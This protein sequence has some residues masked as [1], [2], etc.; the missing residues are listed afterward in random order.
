MNKTIQPNHKK[1]E[2]FCIEQHRQEFPE[3]TTEIWNN[4]AENDLIDSGWVDYLLNKNLSLSILRK[5]RKPT[6]NPYT[7]YGLDGLSRK[8]DQINLIQVKYYDP[9]HTISKNS[10]KTF[11]EIHKNLKTKSYLYHIGKVYKEFKLIS[12]MNFRSPEM[13]SEYSIKNLED[14]QY[15]DIIDESKLWEHQRD[16]LKIMKDIMEDTGFK[17]MRSLELCPGGGKTD[18]TGV[19]I[20]SIKKIKYVIVLNYRIPFVQQ[21][22]NR[23]S[24]YIEK[25]RKPYIINSE[26]SCTV[27]HILNTIGKRKALINITYDSLHLIKDVKDFNDAFFIVDESHCMTPSIID[28]LK[29]KRGYCMTGTCVDKIST[30]F[31]KFYSLPLSEAIEKKIVTDYK[32][33]LPIFDEVDEEDE[34]EEERLD[35]FI[36]EKSDFENSD[37]LTEFE[38][39]NNDSQY[40]VENTKLL[41]DKVD[42]LLTG[43]LKTGA[44]YNITYLYGKQECRNFRK[45]LEKRASSDIYNVNIDVKIVIHGV[46][47]RDR[48]DIFNSFR[49]NKNDGIVLNIIL[50]C[51]VLDMAIDLKLCDSVYFTQKSK[52]KNISLFVQRICRGNRIDKGNK[53]KFTRVFI[54]G[55]DEC[56]DHL[57]NLKD[58]DG[59]FIDKVEKL[60]GDYTKSGSDDR[61]IEIDETFNV[62]RTI[63]DV[64]EQEKWSVE[65]KFTTWLDHCSKKGLVL[66]KYK[67]EKFNMGSFQD[68]MFYAISGRSNDYKKELPG[69]LEKIEQHEELCKN[70]QV[71]IDKLK[72]SGEKRIFSNEEKFKIWFDYCSKKGIAPTKYIIDDFCLGGFQNNLIHAIGGMKNLYAK[73]V[74]NW[75]EKIKEN[76]K[77]YVSILE[78][79]DNIKE[80]KE[81]EK[82]TRDEKFTKW[83]EY[84][85]K[86]VMPDQDFMLGN[87]NLGRFQSS[88]L[89]S[90]SDHKRKLFKNKKIEWMEKIKQNDKLYATIVKRIGKTK[91]IRKIEKYTTNEKFE[92]WFEYCKDNGLVQKTF[93]LDEFQMGSFQNL[94][95]QAIR[96]TRDI[97]KK[98]LPA[99]LEKIKQEKKLYEAIRE[100]TE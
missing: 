57:I 10:L 9:L 26:S 94:L 55:N 28:Y 15:C 84:C 42:F 95:L 13:N 71:R 2:Y 68:C 7:E 29:D 20:S 76:E 54:Y 48:Q 36:E 77:L 49:D 23:L 4:V 34:L 46:Q 100:R 99:W 18:L 87:F 21:N 82:F 35:Q 50:N 44:R 47:Q 61:K 41:T 74:V 62:R 89:S 67:S 66:S 37:K 33:Y 38:D 17:P 60:R 6:I 14:D 3:F 16:I 5:N 86:H 32:I 11:A 69:W 96:G 1:Y 19:F 79:I 53:N 97:Y 39:S 72:L 85:T 73:E 75:T 27:E 22:H 81:E 24:K 88:L 98:D 59:C 58:Y 40:T 52:I 90:L 43:M 25:L 91:E 8:N 45:I 80:K 92:K 83:F 70:I 30:V 31:P 93:I 64:I 65:R 51:H 56:I 63:R 12:N 78:K